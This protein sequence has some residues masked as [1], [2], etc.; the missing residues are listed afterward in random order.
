MSNIYL[1]VTIEK[2]WRMQN[3]DLIILKS[4]SPGQFLGAPTHADIIKFS[5]FLLQL[6]NQ[7]SESKTVCGFSILF[8]L[9]GTRSSLPAVNLCDWIS[10]Q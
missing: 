2:K 10:E 3:F 4:S 7:R 9:K 6:K 5:N 1:K 8:I